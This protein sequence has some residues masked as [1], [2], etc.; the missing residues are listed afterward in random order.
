LFVCVCRGP[1][2]GRLVP[3]QKLGFTVTITCRSQ[4]T[5]LST[6]CEVETGEK[7]LFRIRNHGSFHAPSRRSPTSIF[8][9]S[10]CRRSSLPLGITMAAIQQRAGSNTMMLSSLA[11]RRCVNSSGPGRRLL[12]F[13]SPTLTERR[14]GEAG[15]GG[16]NS[17]A[18]LKVC[19]FGASGFLGEHVCSELGTLESFS[20]EFYLI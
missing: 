5:K 15:T 6:H 8:V 14:V 3:C 4:L 12:S 7:T 19:L 1:R 9:T 13:Y 11:A 10:S 16:R 17:E 20:R 2:L 18:S